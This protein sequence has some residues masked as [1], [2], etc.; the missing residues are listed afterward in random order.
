MMIQQIFYL[1][2]RKNL[3]FN[4]ALPIIDREVEDALRN[5]D[6]SDKRGNASM[7]DI[8]IEEKKAKPKGIPKKWAC[9]YIF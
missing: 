5:Q 9:C 8:V 7:P 3:L 1:M 4:A 6:F 2:R